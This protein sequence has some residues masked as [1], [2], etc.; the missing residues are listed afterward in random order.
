MRRVHLGTSGWAYSSWSPGFYPP[1]TP[2]SKYLGYYASQLNC[3]EVNYTFRAHPTAKMLANWCAATPPDFQFAFKAHQRITHIKRLRDVQPDVESFFGVLEPLREAGRLG[4]V[5]FQL[6]PNLKADTDRLRAFL[7][8]I[9][10][11][12]GAALEF[13]HE[14]WFADAV[15]DLMREHDVALCIAE[16][17]DLQ[18]PEVHTASFAYYRFRRSEYSD[19]DVQALQAR[20]AEAARDRE[21]FAFLKH[22]ESPEGALNARRLLEAFSGAPP[23]A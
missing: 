17:D 10:R 18:V 23:V 8:C 21:V 13:R 19:S 7:Q 20:L 14:S 9:P 3:V 5:L 12:A 6:P 4:P 16:S 1:R 15:F 22:E 2:S 11:N